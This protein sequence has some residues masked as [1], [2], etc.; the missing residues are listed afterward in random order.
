LRPND[1]LAI[2][3]STLLLAAAA[4]LAGFIPALRE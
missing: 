1:P 3:G 2:G 4:G